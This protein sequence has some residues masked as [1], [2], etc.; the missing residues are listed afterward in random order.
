MCKNHASTG[1]PHS[2]SPGRSHAAGF[3]SRGKAP[4]HPLRHLSGQS[5]SFGV[6]P[7]HPHPGDGEC[8]LPRTKELSANDAEL[9]GSAPSLLPQA[10]A[11]VE[12]QRRLPRTQPSLRPA[13]HP[14]STDFSAAPGLLF[15]RLR[16]DK[17]HACTRANE[18]GRQ[19]KPPDPPP[20]KE[21]E[22]KKASSTGE[23][24]SERSAREPG[25][26]HR[27]PEHAPTPLRTSPQARS[28]S[29]VAYCA[30]RTGAV[31][32]SARQVVRVARP[33][34]PC[35]RSP[36]GAERFVPSGSRGGG[37]RLVTS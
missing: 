35:A 9:R 36:A 24:N 32:A 6:V 28:P 20:N 19:Q 33:R 16:A 25:F 1:D 27:R 21:K 2:T 34:L 31:T 8:K 10:G 14:R 3:P 22:G 26:P 29:R 37:N 12:P 4:S 30:R 13:A 18:T 11:Q 5:G 7:A 23:E 17:S 15:A